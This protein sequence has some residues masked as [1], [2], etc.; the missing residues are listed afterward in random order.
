MNIPVSFE[1]GKARRGFEP[2]AEPETIQPDN[3]GT[4]RIEMREV[5]R[6]ELDLGR[7]IHFRGYLVVNEQLRPLPIG[8]TLDPRAGTFNWMP[9]PGFLGTYD[10]IF[11]KQDDLSMAY[12]IPIK[13]TIRPK[14]EKH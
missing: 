9:G 1:P 8:S 7:A 11:I 3:Y 14:F 6:I 12:R 10:F 4:M 13:L 2:R 5:E